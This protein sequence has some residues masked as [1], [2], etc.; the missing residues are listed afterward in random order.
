[1]PRPRHSRTK[2]TAPI[3]F[4]IVS[5]MH[6]RHIVSMRPLSHFVTTGP[7]TMRQ[8]DTAPFVVM[9]S[10]KECSFM[11]GQLFVN[12]DSNRRS[13][14]KNGSPAPIPRGQPRRR[15]A[16]RQQCG[17][18]QAGQQVSAGLRDRIRKGRDRATDRARPTAER[19]G[20][21]GREEEGVKEG[22][23]PRLCVGFQV[24]ASKKG[25]SPDFAWA[26]RFQGDPAWGHP[27]LWKLPSAW[28]PTDRRSRCPAHPNEGERQSACPSQGRSK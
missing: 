6:C 3:R 1:M 25:S 15:A 23:K 19:H 8:P 18:A 22:V 17:R 11:H 9:Q 4:F 10:V 2:M 28:L 26:F 12:G 14:A 24:P 20:R 21:R 27:K 16:E 7:G 5:S 13:C